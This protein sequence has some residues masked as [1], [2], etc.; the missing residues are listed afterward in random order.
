M[1]RTL[2]GS[3]TRMP[4][5]FLVSTASLFFLSSSAY[6]SAS[7]TILSTSSLPRVEAPVICSRKGDVASLLAGH[8]H[9]RRRAKHD[10]QSSIW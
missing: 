2:H 3:C 1:G 9:K 7:E 10:V 4:T 8:K 6:F 5:W